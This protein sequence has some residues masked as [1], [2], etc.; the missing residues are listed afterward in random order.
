MTLEE[1]EA[2][3]AKRG[4]VPCLTCLLFAE[5]PDLAAELRAA[6][7]KDSPTA[8]RVLSGYLRDHHGT[9]IGDSA[10]LGHFTNH[11]GTR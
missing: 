4:G 11:E 6:R 3:N 2:Q 10:L 9:R 1:Y 5:R 7:T 8:F